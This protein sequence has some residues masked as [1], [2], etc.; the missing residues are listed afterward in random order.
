MYTH[1]LIDHTHPEEIVEANDSL[2]TVSC[3][4][5]SWLATSLAGFLV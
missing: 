2:T 4:E 5:D 3:V 1:I